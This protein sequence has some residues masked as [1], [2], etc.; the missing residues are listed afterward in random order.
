MAA[1]RQ[2][3]ANFWLREFPCW[4]IA[5]EADVA[6]LA[7]TVR[8]RL[9]P[10][11]NEFGRLVPTS[12]R[13]WSK[14]CVPRVGAHADA[15]TVDFVPQDA[16]IPAVH[17]WMAANVAYGEV[18]DE[19]NHIHVTAPGVGDP[20]GPEALIGSRATGFVAVDPTVGF[21]GGAGTFQKPFRLPGL[22]ATAAPAGGLPGWPLAGSD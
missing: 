10:A 21:P 1:D 22:V 19:F 5:S 4:E 3:G 8:D 13:W 7:E 18:I 9:Q 16:P 14:G 17:A 11:R 15:R 6:G 20:Q 12:W 2:L